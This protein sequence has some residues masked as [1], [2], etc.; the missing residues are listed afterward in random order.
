M[1]KF[2]DTLSF[3]VGKMRVRNCV[4]VKQCLDKL[5]IPLWF[6][7]GQYVS[8][9]TTFHVHFYFECTSSL[10]IAFGAD[11]TCPGHISKGYFFTSLATLINPF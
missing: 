11:L 3:P 9:S 6:R 4:A 7:E 2:E 10:A 5:P 8:P 1:R